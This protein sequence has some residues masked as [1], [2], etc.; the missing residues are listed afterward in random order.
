M[1]GEEAETRLWASAL[2]LLTIG[3]MLPGCGQ[4]ELASVGGGLRARVINASLAAHSVQVHMTSEMD[5]VVGNTTV[6][7]HPETMVSVTNLL[8]GLWD[9]MVTTV[10]EGGMPIRRLT[11]S[12]LAILDGR[13]TEVVLDLAEASPLDPEPCPEGVPA[14]ICTECVDGVYV[15]IDHDPR[16]EPI[17]CDGFGGRRLSGSNHAAG[18]STCYESVPENI[19]GDLCA[20]PGSCISASPALCPETES[21]RLEAGLCEV[22]EGC[23]VGSPVVVVV[24]DGTSCGSGRIC[25]TGDC[26]EIPDEPDVPVE[27]SVGCSDG[28]REGFLNVETH[29]MIAGCAGAWTEAGVTMPSPVTHCGRQSGNNSSNPEGEGCGAEDLCAPGWHVCEG[30][31]DVALSSP[32]G[33]DEAVPPAAPAKSLFFAVN[34]NS[35]QGSVCDDSSFG[36]DVFGCGNLGTELS[37][38]KNCGPLTRVLASMHSDTCGYNEAEPPLGPWTCIGGTQGHLSEGQW[39]RKNGCPWTSCSYDGVPVGNMD[40]GGVLCCH[41]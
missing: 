21:V 38:D 31:D 34:Q 12:D 20:G 15:E 2:G 30:K 23:L 8:P 35:T 1:R 14:P 13:L 41:N 29:P 22:L 40:K 3:L 17:S 37:T 25:E 36:N 18:L 24:P 32:T 39:V 28:I 7:T 5:Q 11:V 4:D 26:V 33:C 16:C 27:P 9:L 6:V 10:S 19:S